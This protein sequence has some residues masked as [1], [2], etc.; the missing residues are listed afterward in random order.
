MRR[1]LAVL[2]ALVLIGAGCYGLACV[3][4]SVSCPKG[5]HSYIETWMPIVTKYSTTM[6]PIYGC[7]AA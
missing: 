5:Q 7:E 2:G 1:V 3:N 6:V 4:W